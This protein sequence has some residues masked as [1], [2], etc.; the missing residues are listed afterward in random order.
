MPGFEPPF[1]MFVDILHIHSTYF[2]SGGHEGTGIT[3]HCIQD[4]DPMFCHHVLLDA[5]DFSNGGGSAAAET[6][7]NFG[8]FLKEKENHFNFISKNCIRYQRK[9]N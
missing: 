1:V 4:D 5:N 9:S 2:F 8:W 3:C 6:N 7:D